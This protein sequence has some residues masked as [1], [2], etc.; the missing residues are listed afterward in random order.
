M[1][2]YRNWPAICAIANPRL[3]LL[4]AL[5]ADEEV[6][7]GLQRGFPGL[8]TDEKPQQDGPWPFSVL[9]HITDKNYADEDSDQVG[10]DVLE[11]FGLPGIQASD[12]LD[13]MGW[14]N[15]LQLLQTHVDV[16]KEMWDKGGSEKMFPDNTRRITIHNVEYYV[17]YVEV[18]LFPFR[19]ILY[20][21]SLV[22]ENA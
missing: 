14:P 2:L 8:F 18:G 4:V 16:L 13:A 7:E 17:G 20:P 10:D 1:L 3:K 12:D 21:C 11:A 5:E 9:K 19:A 6:L 15:G 22:N